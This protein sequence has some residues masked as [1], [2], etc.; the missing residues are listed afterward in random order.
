[1]NRRQRVQSNFE[2]PVSDGFSP[3]I[4]HSPISLASG[5][6]ISTKAPF[7]SNTDLG[8][9]NSVRS[10]DIVLETQPQNKAVEASEPERTS[11][12]KAAF[13]KEAFTRLNTSEATIHEIK[14][15]K[16]SYRP[17]TQR[18]TSVK[19]GLRDLP[20]SNSFISQSK[21]EHQLELVASEIYEA[22]AEKSPLNPEASSMGSRSSWEHTRAERNKRYLA[23][24]K[25]D[26]ETR[27]DDGSDLGLEC[28][29]SSISNPIEAISANIGAAEPGKG[30]PKGDFHH[31]IEAIERVS[32]SNLTE[33]LTASDDSSI[34]MRR[35]A[36]GKACGPPE[37][38]LLCSPKSKSRLEFDV[39]PRVD[40]TVPDLSRDEF[41][42]PVQESFDNFHASFRVIHD[43]RKPRISFKELKGIQGMPLRNSDVAGLS[44]QNLPVP[45]S[46][47]PYEAAI[48]AAG[49]S[50]EPHM[51]SSSAFSDSTA[52][53]CAVTTHSRLGSSPPPHLYFHIRSGP[54]RTTSD[55]IESLNGGDISSLT[56]S[57]LDENAP[58]SVA[59]THNHAKRMDDGEVDLEDPQE[60]V[61]H[62]KEPSAMV[63]PPK[64]EITVPFPSDRDVAAE[65]AQEIPRTNR[66]F[67]GELAN[68]LKSST[69]DEG[70]KPKS[71]PRFLLSHFEPAHGHVTTYPKPSPETKSCIGGGRNG[72]CFRDDTDIIGYQVP[73]GQAHALATPASHRAESTGVHE[74]FE[75]GERSPEMGSKVGLNKHLAD[76]HMRFIYSLEE[77]GHEHNDIDKDGTSVETQSFD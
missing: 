57:C 38:E 37:A 2:H 34:E 53:S 74:P 35:R 62:Y 23:L 64:P 19:T 18:T 68:N 60:D 27:S 16:T 65:Q 14:Q 5:S 51:R 56:L 1:M 58:P 63:V 40:L 46:D 50:V 12:S 33:P 43:N 7:D 41:R 9:A 25:Y 67:L 28:S 39:D 72:V 73:Q 15:P 26:E 36:S 44:P 24:P 30:V 6:A 21:F 55:I 31:D 13:A 45:A 3:A 66:E 59:Q 52:S 77:D 61:D 47:D 71:K 10:P 32:G 76:L 29:D 54:A 17:P 4:L 48:K 42:D 22:D 20:A 49:L 8:P 70:L 75:V 69:N 11:S